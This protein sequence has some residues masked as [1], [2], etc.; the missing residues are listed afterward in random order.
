MRQIYRIPYQYKIIYIFSA[1]DTCPANVLPMHMPKI[2]GEPKCYPYNFKGLPKL[3]AKLSSTL[4]KM[5]DVAAPLWNSAQGN[6]SEACASISE[7]LAEATMVTKEILLAIE[8]T[9]IDTFTNEYVLVGIFDVLILF[10]MSMQRIL[11]KSLF[12]TDKKDVESRPKRSLSAAM[13]IGNVR[14][15]RKNRR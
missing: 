11:P 4:T 10:L 3:T 12:V 14:R 5:A 8:N 13:K 1:N 7:L 2:D 6:A 9:L 15:R